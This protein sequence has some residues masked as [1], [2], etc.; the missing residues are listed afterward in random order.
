MKKNSSGLTLIELLLTVILI[1]V[2]VL[3]LASIQRFAF[4]N[5]IASERRAKLQNE[6]YLILE[7]M[8]KDVMQ[9]VGDINNPAIQVY[10][11][12]FAVRRWASAVNT[13]HTNFALYRYNITN[14]AVQYCPQ[15]ESFPSHADIRNNDCGKSTWEDLSRKVTTASFIAGNN[16]TTLAINLILQHNVSS[17]LINED[18]PQVNLTSLVAIPAASGN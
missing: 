14:H 2:L 15:E 12:G 16:N 1:G 13:A 17:A 10:T 7:Y 3:A 8:T 4:H 5:V 6:A 18:N 11:N 9:G